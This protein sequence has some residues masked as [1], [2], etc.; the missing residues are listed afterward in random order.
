MKVLVLLLI[1]MSMLSACEPTADE[2]SESERRLTEA[3]MNATPEGTARHTE[4][5][6]QLIRSDVAKRGR[7]TRQMIIA[8]VA[9]SSLVCGFITMGIANSKALNLEGWFLLGLLFSPIAI[10]VALLV[11]KNEKGLVAKA[12]E[13]GEMKNCPHCGEAI[14]IEAIRCR[15]C[16]GDNAKALRSDTAN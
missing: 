3:I 16:G 14:K 2:M 13:R 15:F 6:I 8:I 4:L 9:I 1:M 12:I 10:I 5:K 7:E 11:P